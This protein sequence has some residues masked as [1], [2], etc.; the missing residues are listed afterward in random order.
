M[1]R[2]RRAQRGGAVVE[3][4]ILAPILVVLVLWSNYFWE[5]QHARIKAAEIARFVAFERT[6]RPDLG[7]IA[8]EA[9]DRYKDLDGT[10]KGVELGTAYRNRLTINVTAR[11]AP[12]PLTGMSLSD[13]G[14]K[15]GAG[16]IAGAAMSVLGAVA[17]EVAQ[18]MDLDPNQGAV[19]ADVEVKIEN[20]IIPNEIALYT[21][22]FSDDRLNL[23]LNERFY[24]FHDTWRAWGYGDNPNNTYA[25]VQQITYDRARQITYA[26]ITSGSAGGALDAIG[27]VLSVLGLDFPFSD[28]YVRDSFLMRPVPQNGY[29]NATTPTRTVPGDRLQAAYWRSDTRACLN[30]CEP[31][32]I[33]QKRGYRSS[34]DYNDNWPMRSYN[35]RGKFFQGARQS[36]QTESEYSQPSGPGTSYFTYG[37]NACQ[38]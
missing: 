21:T 23:T 10:T 2:G 32:I 27:T 31:T 28:S 22:G 13:M 1:L 14:T 30:S 37:R 24:M 26:G 25:R 16:G 9:K 38:E 19:Q 29:Y 18:K 8:A 4:A 11:N 6:V 34:G 33:K 7:A 20:A 36:N 17:G 12:A 15:G 3:F 5:V 35:C